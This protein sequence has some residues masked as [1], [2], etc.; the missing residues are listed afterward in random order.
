MSIEKGE[1]TLVHELVGGSYASSLIV[2][3]EGNVYSGS[4][5]TSIRI[6]N[7][8]GE[9]LRTLIGHSHCVWCVELISP[10]ERLIR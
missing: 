2:D 7:S 8:R 9:L 4:E 3:D 5:D 1:L 10:M 6:W